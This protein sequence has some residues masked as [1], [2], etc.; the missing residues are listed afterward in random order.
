[1]TVEDGSNE[2]ESAPLDRVGCWQL[3]ALFAWTTLTLGLI[4]I[5]V[6]RKLRTEPSTSPQ[7]WAISFGI[8]TS[9]AILAVAGQYWSWRR[10]GGQHWVRLSRRVWRTEQL[11]VTQAAQSRVLH[12]LEHRNAAMEKQVLPFIVLGLIW[13]T[14]A[15]FQIA[16]DPSSPNVAGWLLLG[17][18]LCGLTAQR[19]W[20]E[21]R[22]AQL[23]HV[24]WS[25]QRDTTTA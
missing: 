23:R 17:A 9:A 25:L 5:D 2:S 18:A 13:I 12:A 24:I 16:A 11:P 20:D 19:M 15:I 21:R 22:S 10:Q 8:A 14:N 6:V 4:G 7:A 1:M 3:V